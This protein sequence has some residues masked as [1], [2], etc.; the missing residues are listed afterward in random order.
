MPH[1]P[2]GM[3][4]PLPG[5]L[6]PCWGVSCLGFRVE[7][8]VDSG[9][10]Q[11][12]SS[13]A[14][15]WGLL[16]REPDWRLPLTGDLLASLSGLM[17]ALPFWLLVAPPCW[18]QRRIPDRLNCVWLWGGSHSSHFPPS[19]PFRGDLLAPSFQLLVALPCWDKTLGRIWDRLSCVALGWGIFSPHVTSLHTAK[20]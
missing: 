16:A 11:G 14:L 13:V 12:L 5:E 20:S 17:E 1:Q 10:C 4:Q 3:Q 9:W 7:V 18:G 6:A 15:E 19:L 2:G 8:W